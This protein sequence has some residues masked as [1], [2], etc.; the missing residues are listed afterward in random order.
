MNQESRIMAWTLGTENV[1][2]TPT[3]RCRRWAVGWCLLMAAALCC[4]ARWCGAIGPTGETFALPR[5]SAAPKIDGDISDAVWS[6]AK[7]LD[8]SWWVSS[9]GAQSKDRTVVWIAC[10]EKT[11]YVAFHAYGDPKK[12]RADAVRRDSEIDGD[13]W[14]GIDID[15]YMDHRTIYWFDVTPRGTQVDHTP[16]G[17][18]SKVQ[19]KGDWRAAGKIVADG[20][21]AE[22]AIPFSFF[23]Y[24]PNTTQFGINFLRHC[25]DSL[26]TSWWADMG[27]TEDMTRMGTMTGLVLPN[28]GPPRPTIMGYVIGDAGKGRDAGLRSGLDVKYQPTSDYTT[29]LTVNPDFRSVEQSVDTIDFSYSQRL[30]PDARPFFAEGADSF[31]L[32]TARYSLFDSRAN[33]GPID[34]GVK[35][36][37]KTGQWTTAFLDAWRYHTRNDFV[38]HVSYDIGA[39]S[40]A[41]L[42]ATQVTGEGPSNDVVAGDLWLGS[43]GKTLNFSYVDSSFGGDDPSRESAWRTSAE[44]DTQHWEI[45]GSL[46]DVQPGFALRDGLVYDD[47]IRGPGGYLS[48]YNRQATGKIVQ[49]MVYFDWAEMHDHQGDLRFIERTLGGNL[50]LRRD[51][52]CTVYQSWYTRP[53]FDDNYHSVW[54]GWNMRKTGKSAGITY[55]W[56]RRAG[57]D[58]MLLSPDFAFHPLKPLYVEVLQ[59]RLRM[60]AN[61]ETQ[62]VVTVTY[63]LTAEKSLSGRWIGRA[64][65]SNLSLA[66]RQA[67]RHGM[68]IYVIY[69]DP[70][71]DETDQRLAVKLLIPL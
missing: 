69:G 34:A 56:G 55:R 48:W 44:R 33:I 66:Y 11:L 29:L 26:D 61:R 10:D 57:E 50:V 8:R 20:W 52:R 43:P 7:K 13:D 25:T 36:F 59:E 21:T 16:G 67:V 65:K 53:P 12:V 71:A 5:L 60:G 17:T 14:V 24:P 40:G 47:D 30:L 31:G 41:G 19:W 63:E 32:V 45:Y 6:E 22:M 27:T 18:T 28:L 4:S 9:A 42:F 38:G 37:G 70:N 62:T 54:I 1:T 49:S 2:V 39:Y 46:T 23:T 64:G 51:I 58:Y 35:G 3:I 15:P 68:D